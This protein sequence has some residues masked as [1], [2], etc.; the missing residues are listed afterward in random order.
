MKDTES[1]RPQ[2]WRNE[3]FGMKI[4]KVDD[5]VNIIKSR[6]FK[7]KKISQKIQNI[8]NNGFEEKEL[9][10]ENKKPI[11]SKLR[12]TELLEKENSPRKALLL[13]GLNV[14]SEEDSL[15]VKN[16]LLNIRNKISTKILN[17]DKDKLKSLS[18]NSSPQ[19][20]PDILELK[21]KT[22]EIES[23]EEV[24]NTSSVE[25]NS[26]YINNL[27]SSQLNIKKDILNMKIKI[28]KKRKDENEFFNFLF[29]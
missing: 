5:L 16:K 22:I 26:G 20:I 24:N 9:K 6:N 28:S 19:K 18:R 27:S 25:E 3:I 13:P 12:I 14:K 17:L 8:D 23:T 4:P 15:K 29:N 11:K 10:K 21:A 7:I 2:M 1:S